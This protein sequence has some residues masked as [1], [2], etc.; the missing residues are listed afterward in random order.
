MAPPEQRARK[1]FR[2]SLDRQVLRAQPERQAQLVQPEPQVP[3]VL[4]GRLG[5]RVR[6]DQSALLARRAPREPQEHP[7]Q[8]A[9]QA[10][11]D[12]QAQPAQPDRLVNRSFLSGRGIP[13]QT[14]QSAKLFRSPDRATFRSSTE[15]SR[16]SRMPTEE[17]TGRS[18]L[19]QALQEQPERMVE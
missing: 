5:R 18:W 17:F 12:R 7:A 14:T 2:E 1:E 15:T 3:R 9:Q 6:K 10:T 8:L 19:K 4:L 13:A 11:W 16:T